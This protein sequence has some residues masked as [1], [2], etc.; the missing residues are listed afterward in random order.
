LAQEVWFYHLETQDL[1]QALGA[2]LEKGLARGWR[3]VV[4][5]GDAARLDALDAALWTY[6][7]D[8]FLPHGK[9][10]PDAGRQPVAL[11]ASTANPNGGQALFLVE[12]AEPT[13]LEG[14]ARVCVVFDG[15]DEASLAQAR[16]HWRAV[17]ASG[18]QAV[19][20]KQTA[21]GGWEKKG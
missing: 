11:T 1:A 5:G 15:R 6:R 9:D 3:A 17:K 8:S 20:W 10:G 16:V 4:R 13:A 14:Y 12:G 18:A 2:L 7:D 19:Y 21:S